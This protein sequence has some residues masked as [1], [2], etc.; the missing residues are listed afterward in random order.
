MQ[1]RLDILQVITRAMEEIVPAA[2]IVTDA[3]EIFLVLS[4]D[5]V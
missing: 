3:L 2:A 4:Q 1:E 5:T